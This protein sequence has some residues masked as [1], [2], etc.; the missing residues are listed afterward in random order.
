MADVLIP[1]ALILLGGALLLPV[2][3]RRWRS[4]F[5]VILGAL[6]LLLVLSFETGDFS[7]SLRMMNYDLMPLRVDG[8]SRGFGIIFGIIIMIGGIYAYHLKDTGQQVAALLYGAGALGVVFAGDFYSLFFFWELMG[9]SS[10]VLIWAR[11]QRRSRRAGIRYII[12]HALGGGIL[13]AGIL[14]HL[15]GGGSLEISS[16]ASVKA[17]P[18]WLMLIGVLINTAVPPLHTWLVDA[19]PKATITGVIFLNAFTTKSAVYALVRLFPGWEILVILGTVMA[20]YG[21]IFTVLANDMRGILAYHVVS[22]VGYMVA[23]VGIG[24]P[25]ALNGAVAHA[26]SNIFFK[27]L[28]FMAAGA[29]MTA[30]G[31]SRLTELGGLHRYLPWVWPLYM[32]GAFSIAGFPLFNGFVSKSM[33]LNAASNSH[34]STV[35]LLLTLA[36]VGTFLSVGLKLPF[37]AFFDRSKPREI[38]VKKVPVN[39]IVAMIVTGLFCVFHGTFVCSFTSLLPHEVPVHPY[40]LHHLMEVVQ[41]FSMVFIGFWIFRKGLL[42]PKKKMLLD[43]DWLFRKPAGL[44]REIGVDGTVRVFDTVGNLFNALTRG[45]V[46]LGRNPMGLLYKS[47]K[48]K[49]RYSPDTY[50]PTVSFML[51]GILFIFLLLVAVAVW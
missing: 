32:V 29:V 1:P 50:R 23:A 20:L 43:V 28:L 24:T 17:L 3:T 9:I 36:A 46:R 45:L 5:F 26:F 38:R 11:R 40:N 30:T 2:L 15:S 27:G 14:A 25:L 49:P 7:L 6:V 37:Y 42:R 35:F 13:M 41:I 51:F 18:G 22:Q 16:V 48:E 4:G 19:Y 39:M 33:I 34:H 12:Y 31:R 44:F 21:V 10:T 8:L 47:G